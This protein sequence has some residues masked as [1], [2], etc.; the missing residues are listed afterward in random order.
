MATEFD[1]ISRGS[2]T[3]PASVSVAGEAARAP[4]LDLQEL[5]AR[6]ILMAESTTDLIGLTDGQGRIVYL[7]PAAR[8][9]L[10]VGELSA[11]L[12]LDVLFP[13]EAFGQYYDV[14][15]PQLLRGEPW[16][17]GVVMR[18]AEG[19]PLRVR[20]TVVAKT[21]AGGEVE[22]LATIGHTI[23]EPRSR[24]TPRRAASPTVERGA[25]MSSLVDVRDAALAHELAIGIG[26][27]SMTVQYQPMIEIA[28]GLVCGVE[29][30][31]RWLHSSRGLLDA[32]EFIDIA[33]RTG[34]V[35]PLGSHVLREACAQGSRWARSSSSAAPRIH[36]NV[37]ARQLVDPGFVELIAEL[38]IDVGL[39]ADRLW[40]EA[41][42]S[43]FLDDVAMGCLEHVRNQGVR[44]AIEVDDSSAVT[45][46]GRALPIDAYKLDR[47]LVAEV[48]QDEGRRRVAQ[49]I[50]LA[51]GLGV[52]VIA[53]GVETSGQLAVLRALDC[54]L[55][56]GLFFARPRRAEGVE[57]LFGRRFVG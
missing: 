42:A 15:R 17:G 41:P 44:V 40:V 23:D 55:A 24:D 46:G 5:A 37:S 10:G 45:D 14:I 30:F 38:L 47:S 26:R 54:D 20:Q 52:V 9:Q 2:A 32:S 16:S 50:E 29:A 6:L 31:A 53:A 8:R 3:G 43:A 19:R 57:L 1:A 36:V 22:W 7:N 49:L 4:T 51:H 13:P 18:D 11:D 39:A 33:N 35:V 21:N 12:T 34:L 28:T 48:Q 27:S 56:Q 25:N